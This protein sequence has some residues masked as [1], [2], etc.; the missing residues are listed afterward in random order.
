MEL[1]K[2]LFIHLV[3]GAVFP[4]ERAFL[5]FLNRTR[6]IYCIQNRLAGNVDLFLSETS[7]CRLRPNVLRKVNQLVISSL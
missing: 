5:R 2:L 6:A 7:S 1:E 3:Q 4:T